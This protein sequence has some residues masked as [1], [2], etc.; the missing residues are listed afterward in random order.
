MIPKGSSGWWNFIT[1]LALTDKPGRLGESAPG[2]SERQINLGLALLLG[3]E[4]LVFI[5]GLASA[6]QR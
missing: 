5:H 1:T 6:T 2:T 4:Q 3:L